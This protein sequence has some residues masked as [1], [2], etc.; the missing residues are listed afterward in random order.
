MISKW[1]TDDLFNSIAMFLPFIIEPSFHPCYT[2]KKN[3]RINM[4]RES[5]II[6]WE[7]MSTIEDGLTFPLLL[8]HS[9]LLHCRLYKDD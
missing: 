6:F 8:S 7:I 9:P 3:K 1:E 5:F 2:K 4:R